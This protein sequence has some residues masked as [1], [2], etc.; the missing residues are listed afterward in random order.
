MFPQSFGGA[1][2]PSWK[3]HTL[4]FILSSKLAGCPVSALLADLISSPF[5]LR[6]RLCVNVPTTVV[7]QT[8]PQS[9]IQLSFYVAHSNLTTSLTVPAVSHYQLPPGLFRRN[10]QKWGSR[11]GRRSASRLMQN[12]TSRS[13]FA[14]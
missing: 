9:S 13:H 2:E 6:S 5:V 7:N 1:M 11:S 12:G 14:C 10:R 3:L 8:I 4:R